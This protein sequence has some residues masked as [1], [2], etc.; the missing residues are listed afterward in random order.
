MRHTLEDLTK[1]HVLQIEKLR[2]RYESQIL[3]LRKQLE[4]EEAR[5]RSRH[6]DELR[7]VEQK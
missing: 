5:L 7:Q 2:H 4:Q 3:S 1:S 6:S